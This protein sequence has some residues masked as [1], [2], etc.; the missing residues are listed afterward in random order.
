V[1]RYSPDSVTLSEASAP[2]SLVIDVADLDRRE[3]KRR[4]MPADEA[5]PAAEAPIDDA[6]EQRA[7]RVIATRP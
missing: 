5:A 7:E 4:G 3:I 6:I 1:V 2:S